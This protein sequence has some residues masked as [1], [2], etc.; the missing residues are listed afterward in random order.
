[1]II[2]VYDYWLNKRLKTVSFFL[3]IK[4]LKGYWYI[5]MQERG[6]S[7]VNSASKI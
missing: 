7:F 3:E 1:L 4:F 5:R 6:I 2:A